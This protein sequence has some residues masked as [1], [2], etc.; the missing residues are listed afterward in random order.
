MKFMAYGIPVML[1]TLVISTVYLY[2]RYY[3]LHW[4]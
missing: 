2:L 1:M 3:V 4:Y